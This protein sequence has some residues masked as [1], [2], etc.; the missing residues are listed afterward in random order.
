MTTL[1]LALLCTWWV[2]GRVRKDSMYE[3]KQKFNEYQL[4]KTKS[5]VGT[6]ID[7]DEGGAWIAVSLPDSQ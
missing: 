1:N 7:V 6:R 5:Q 3:V 2:C 4:K